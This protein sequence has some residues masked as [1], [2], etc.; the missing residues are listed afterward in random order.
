M[1]CSFSFHL[2]L[3]SITFDTIPILMLN[4]FGLLL[5]MCLRMRNAFNDNDC[6][7]VF[8]TSTTKSRFAIDS[9]LTKL[10]VCAT[11]VID[12]EVLVN[13]LGDYHGAGK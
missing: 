12:E 8:S 4:L 1:A 7:S 10:N 5:G 13:S 6:E 3:I 11:L 9:V 2:F